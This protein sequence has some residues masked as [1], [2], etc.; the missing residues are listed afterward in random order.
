[1]KKTVLVLLTFVPFV[2][3]YAINLLLAVPVLG[4]VL[5]FVLPFVALGFWF[6][7]GN[8]YSKTNWKALPSILISSATGILSLVLYIWQFLIESDATRNMFFA[9]LSQMYSTSTPMYL[10]GGL[11]RLFESQPNYA[12]RASFL[13]LQVIAVVLMIVIF[14]GGYF[15]GKKRSKAKNAQSFGG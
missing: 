1:M 8:L 15:W 13:A 11:A 6:Y 4:A 2:V 14:S 12:G 9:A 5:Y 3:G 7:L 10:F